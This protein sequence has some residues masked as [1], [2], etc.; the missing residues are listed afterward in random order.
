[1]LNTAE[2]AIDWIHSRLKFGIRPGLERVKALLTLLDHPEQKIPTIHIAGTNG[3]GSTVSYLRAM[4]AETGLKVGTFTS[5]FIE[6][7]NERI[8]INN[9]PIPDEDLLR[10]V[11]QLQPLVLQVD[12]TEALAGATEF[13]IIT[14][15]GFMYFLEQ[16]VDVAVIEVGLGGLYDSTNV[17]Q[18]VVSAITT[19]GMDHTDILGDTLAE[20]ATQ[21]AGIIK[22]R[23][24]MIT[25]KIAD[26]ALT[27]I[28]TIAADKQ[29]PVD[30][31]ATDYEVQYQHQDKNWGEVFDFYNEAGKISG[32]VTP[33]IGR[34][35]VENAGLAIQVFYRYCQAMQLTFSEKD[36]REGLKQ[37]V[38]PARMERI[39][40]EPFILL[41]G[42]HNE[43]AMKRL[44]ENLTNEFKDYQIHILFSALETKDIT[45][46]LAQLLEVP[47][48]DL[49]ITSFDY[50]KALDLTKGYEQLNPSR[51]QVASYW[52]VG[53]ADL[54][55]KADSESIVLVTGS[56]YFISEVRKLIT[57]MR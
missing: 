42:A 31:F 50:P 29:A 40:A 13:E 16:A 46:M 4:L 11:Q 30:H 18:P 28:E 12:Q 49:L 39:S 53:L 23:T 19:I 8:A 52:Q 7:F 22:Q 35:Q 33:L 38:W 21:K 43:H 6:L 5:P 55:D 47:N 45:Q 51:I 44:V 48:A 41:D 24:P 15:L 9:Q 27:V 37:T 14:V 2:E 34:H 20:I 1:M 54:L 36:V 32:L 10:L 26:E 3:K 17:I 56:L 57:T 25:G